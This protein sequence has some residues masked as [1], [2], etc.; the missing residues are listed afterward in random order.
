VNAL[1]VGVQSLLQTALLAQGV[2]TPTDVSWLEQH[3]LSMQGVPAAERW[4]LHGM[5]S[6][7]DLLRVLLELGA[8]DATEAVMHHQAKPAALGALT[9]RLVERHRALPLSIEGRRVVMAMLDPTDTDSL[10]KLSLYC[11]LVIEARAC[12][13]SVLWQAQHR[14][15]GVPVPSMVGRS[16][17]RVANDGLLP[18]PFPLRDESQ[19]ALERATHK[20]TD[21]E[22]SPLGSA[23][24]AVVGEVPSQGRV[25]W[26]PLQVHGATVATME[27]DKAKTFLHRLTQV[28]SLAEARDSLPPLVWR[29]VMPTARVAAL[30]IVRGTI[31]VGWSGMVRG[32]ASNRAETALRDVLI[33]LAAP[34]C[35]QRAFD[36]H[37]VSLSD[38]RD[39]GTMERTLLRMLHVPL[40]RAACCIPL[41]MEST[42]RALLYVDRDDGPIDDVFVDDGRRA[43]AA[44]GEGLSALLVADAVLA[45]ELPRLQTR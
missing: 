33:P 37:Q 3:P 5:C 1:S 8:S 43:A 13:A 30:F 42:V 11:G 6:Q 23:I 25:A 18:P 16:R 21:V 29:A 22:L 34:S 36:Q 31:A 10:E 20:A 45:K 26:S 38:P 12:K 2:L 41:L 35:L 14:L 28:G 24:A 9:Q 40:P 44:L 27:L 32:D 39:P 7:D 15:Y 19:A 17:A 4:L